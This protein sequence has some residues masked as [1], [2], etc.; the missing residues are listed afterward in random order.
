MKR[1]L[2]VLINL[3]MVSF[4]AAPAL[5]AADYELK[6]GN[7]S[8]QLGTTISVPLTLSSIGD[9]QGF[10]AAFD[11]DPAKL[12]GVDLITSTD[13]SKA[14][15]IVPR[16]QDGSAVL[17]VVMDS[18]G[19]GGEIIPAGS[20]K[21]LATLKVKALGP[22]GETEEVVPLVFQDGKYATVDLG[23]LLDNV[24]VI[25]GLSISKLEELVLTNGSVTLLPPPPAS[26]TID[27]KIGQY[28]DTVKVPIVMGNN[29]DVQGFVTAIAN[30]AGITLTK[31]ERGEAA[32]NADFS[33]EE[34][35]PAGRWG[36]FGV[37]MELDGVPPYK[38]IPAG[39]NNVIAYY[40]YASASRACVT[41]A[42]VQA[43][44]TIYNLTFKDLFY[45][46][47]LKENVIVIEGRSKNPVLNHGTLTL[48]PCIIPG[49]EGV[50][51]IRAG[52]C[53][54]V[55]PGVDVPV[56]EGDVKDPTD[57]TKYVPRPADL[58]AEPCDTVQVGFWYQFPPDAIL[59]DLDDMA[60]ADQIHQIQGMSIAVCYDASKLSCLGTYTLAG[61]ITEAIG[62]EFVNVHCQDADPSEP[63]RPGE[64][65]IGILTDALPPFEGQ[66]LPP[67]SDWLKLLCVDFKVACDAPCNECIA[68]TFC[69]GANGAG[70][71]P[72][73]N[74]ASVWNHSWPMQTFST[75]ICVLAEPK[76]V[77][78]DCNFNG[79][80]HLPSTG[81]DAV[82]IAD[83]AAVLSYLFQTGD[84][85]FA[86]PCM[87]SC[88]ANDDGRV[89][90]ADSVFI[91]RYLF[92]F[93]RKPPEPFESSPG[94]DPTDDRLGC[95]GGNMSCDV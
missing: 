65:V 95:L 21:L 78:G 29:L 62:A 18:D 92:K 35:D 84:W 41:E 33:E 76:F 11:W 60:G 19:Q 31:I 59:D 55:T 16:V 70:N 22:S 82:D 77:R 86:P 85:R 30:D 7:E 72:I 44:T 26:F 37:V 5:T 13:V 28:G 74:L 46:D 15:V 88:D 23:P 87:D 27:S 6:L 3:C 94:F 58:T 32:T 63:S 10:V 9:V 45:G 89:D 73:R 67:S 48:K 80:D 90:L 36:T 91:L 51:K 39:S 53:S 68:I 64:L 81:K 79:I 61:T 14:D 52:G 83:A 54:L 4:L 17:G 69:D 1:V 25:G 24:L 47:P 66:Y 75:E 43:N 12:Q 8:G 57:P 20:N 42:E 38:L 49:E 2:G 71:V 34:I 50:I 93:D 56:Q 40:S